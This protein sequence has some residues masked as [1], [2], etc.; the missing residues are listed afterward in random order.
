[1]NGSIDPHTCSAPRIS[2]AE[3]KQWLDASQD[4]VMLDTRNMYE[5]EHGSF[6]NAL[7]LGIRHF[8][9]FPSFVEKL[10]PALKQRTIVTFCTG[11]IRCEKAGAYMR[12]EGFDRVYQLDGGILKYFEEVGH[13][14]YSGSCFVFDDRISLDPALQPE[15]ELAMNA[16]PSS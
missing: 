16:I 7:T 15:I 4:V 3:L 12:R 14:H 2:P 10:D 5:V 13:E 6:S 11:G 8:R 1:M 9:T